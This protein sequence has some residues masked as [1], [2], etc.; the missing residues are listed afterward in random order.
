VTE[1]GTLPPPPPWHAALA[2]QSAPTIKILMITL[3][4]YLK[5]RTPWENPIDRKFR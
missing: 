1:G 2:M 5:S 3:I 4:R